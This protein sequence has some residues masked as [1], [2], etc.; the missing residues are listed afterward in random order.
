MHGGGGGLPR[1]FFL[2]Q[3]ECLRTEDAVNCRDCKAQWGS[4]MVIMGSEKIDWLNSICMSN[5]LVQSKIL[6][7]HQFQI[8]P[9]WDIH[10][11]QMMVPIILIAPLTSHLVQP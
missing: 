9:K 10:G 6:S 8:T 1:E 2:T 4:V 7:W 11:T 5:T 3:I